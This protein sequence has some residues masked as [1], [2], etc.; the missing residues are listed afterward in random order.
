M[1]VQKLLRLTLAA[2]LSV[3]SASAQTSTGEI[4]G[5]V[6]DSSGATIAGAK[7]VL[8]EQ[9]TNQTREQTSNSAG[10]YEF[11]ALPRGFYTIQVEMS[12]FKKEEI[13]ALQLTVAQ[14]LQLDIK[15]ELGQVTDSVTVEATAGQIQEREA[16]L[17]Q[18]ID[19]R[20]V[21]ELPINGRNF[22]QLA[23]LSSGIVTAGRGSATQRQ[24][25]YGPAFSA[26]GQR[27]N[28]TTVLV[29]GIEISGMELNNYPYAI[30]SLDSVGEFRVLTSGASAEFGGNSGAFVN[31][32]T[33]RGTNQ[34]HGS[35]FEFLR[36]DSARRSE[37]LRR[38]GQVGA[39]QTQPVRVCGR[40]PRF[41]SEAVQRQRQNVLYVQL[42]VA[43]PA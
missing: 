19:E 21:R 27:D 1:A 42:G 9:A 34:L 36:N 31:V 37:F 35:L 2:F 32:V 28:T 24:A 22:M 3:L 25:S 12:G 43:A 41:H 5:S 7:V 14:T 4:T 8:I 16:S 11:H 20:R 40:W 15:L 6:V 10:L 39:E 38:D 18:V 13:R 17:S 23:F 30:P 26:G 33:R 29:D